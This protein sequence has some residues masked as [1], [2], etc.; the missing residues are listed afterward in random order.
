MTT[1]TYELQSKFLKEGYIGFR[2]EGSGLNSLQGA[3]IRT[4]L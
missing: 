4:R 3:Y 2:V 1:S